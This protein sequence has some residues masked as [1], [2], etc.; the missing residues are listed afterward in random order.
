MGFGV[1]IGWTLVLAGRFQFAN[2]SVIGIVV[3]VSSFLMTAMI[4]ICSVRAISGFRVYVPI[5]RK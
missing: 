3:M 2:T 5:T 4:M 1:S